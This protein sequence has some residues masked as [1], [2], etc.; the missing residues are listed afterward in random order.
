VKKL[1]LLVAFCANS[2]G[3]AELLSDPQQDG[4]QATS[5]AVTPSVVQAD[6]ANLAAYHD[7]NASLPPPIPGKPR[8]VFLGDSITQGWELGTSKLVRGELINRGISGQTTPQILLRFRQD[9]INL[10]P[11]IVHIIAG[12]NDIAE[13]TGRTTLEAIE[14][15]LMSMVDLAQKNGIRVVLASLP[16]AADFPWRPGLSPAAKIVAL[17]RWIRDYASKKGL[18]F[19]DYHAQLADAQQGF[20]TALSDDG[21]HPN[22]DGYTVMSRVAYEAFQKISRKTK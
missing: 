12:T 21:V 10:Q 3:A 20:K 9:V 11:N 6:W 14:N 2:G 4:V 8:I 13:N 16:P 5:Q 15:N 19:I 7:A 17:D 1:I 22:K 18:I